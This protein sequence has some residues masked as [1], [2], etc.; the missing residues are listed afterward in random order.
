VDP[1]P[2]AEQPRAA[3]TPAL[4]ATTRRGLDPGTRRQTYVVAAVIA[5]LFYGS[6]IL[7]EA[8]PANAADPAPGTPVSI[9]ETTQITPLEGWSVT[10]HDNGFG[11]RLEKG[12]VVVDLYQ[13][14]VGEDA[15]EL[16]AAYLDEVLRPDSSQFT[17]SEIEV[18][19]ASNGTAARFNYQGF[20]TGVEFAIEGEVTAIF[21]DGTGIVADAWS[22]QGDLG[23]LLGEVH[24]M[25][26]SV[27]FAS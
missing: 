9:G 1:A 26:A 2:S 20:F 23:D 22:R 19:T 15:R 7:N 4:A 10:A 6:Q 21:V 16:A 13:E 27:E 12:I 25:L 24:D 8:L 14:A 3:P 18:V 11:V 5:L 17:S